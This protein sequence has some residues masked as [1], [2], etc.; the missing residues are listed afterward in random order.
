MVLEKSLVSGSMSLL[1][2]KLLED[3][4]LYGYQMIE[5]L[6]RRSEDAFRLRAGTLYPLLHSLEE[7]G[8]VQAYEQ[9]AESGKSR[10]YYHLTRQGRNALREK[11]D[12]PEV[13]H[14]GM[15]VL[16]QQLL[17]AQAIG[18]WLEELKKDLVPGGT[19][20]P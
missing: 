12:A 9:T 11:E 13:P 8:L 4:D 20:L 7:K 19:D 3:G 17:L 2:L 6:R 10:R 5:E 14:A 16:R 18:A 15:A 1:T